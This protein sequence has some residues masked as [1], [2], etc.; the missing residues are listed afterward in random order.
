MKPRPV[1]YHP[2]L[3][4][5]GIG[6]RT[7]KIPLIVVNDATLKLFARLWKWLKRRK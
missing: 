6:V 4:E 3:R 1:N 2:V 7:W 5:R